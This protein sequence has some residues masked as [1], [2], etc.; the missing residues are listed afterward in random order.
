M[1]PVYSIITYV[2]LCGYS[3]FRS[4]DVKQLIKETTEAKIEFHER[5]WKNI[6]QTGQLISCSPKYPNNLNPFLAKDFIV[7][8]L[9]PD[10]A[11]RLTAEEALDHPVR[12]LH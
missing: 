10:P 5:Y 4:D 9:N 1:L 2:L 11:K 6:S 3:P 7:A 8:L 12:P